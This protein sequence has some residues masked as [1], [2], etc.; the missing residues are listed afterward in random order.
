MSCC[1]DLVAELL[2][3]QERQVRIS[4][5]LAGVIAALDNST[6]AQKLKGFY[7]LHCHHTVE[8]PSNMTAMTN[9]DHAKNDDL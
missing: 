4:V 8:V 6:C 3:V 7:F 5:S 1:N 9:N 2:T